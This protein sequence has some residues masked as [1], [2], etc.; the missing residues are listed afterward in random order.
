MNV[1]R[2]VKARPVTPSWRDIA[3]NGSQGSV[4][5]PVG[6]YHV[7]AVGLPGSLSTLMNTRSLPVSR[8]ASDAIRCSTASRSRSAVMPAVISRRPRSSSARSASSDR[9]RV[10][11]SI[12]RAFVM[13]RDAWSESAVSS[14]A[15]ASS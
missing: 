4:P 15:S 11:A 2:S 9:D 13:A 12:L 6:E 5:V 8:D 7:H 10:S 1:C 14:S 3:S